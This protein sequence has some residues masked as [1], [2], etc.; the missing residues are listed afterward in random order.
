MRFKLLFILLVFGLYSKGAAQINP[1]TPSDPKKEGVVNIYQDESIRRLLDTYI[2]ANAARPGMQGFRVRIFF[3]LGQQ[4]RTTSLDEQTKFMETM[5]GINVYRTFDSPYYKVSVGDF[6]T[7]DE[8]L[9][10]L[11]LIEKQ[12]PKA[13][14]VSEWI[15]FPKLN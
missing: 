10:L 5:P 2:I 1:I 3:D 15:H 8:A 14:I 6:R 4:S 7:R 9:K 12:Y 11:K 13:F